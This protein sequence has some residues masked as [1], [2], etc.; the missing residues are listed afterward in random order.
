MPLPSAAKPI[1]P[2]VEQRSSKVAVAGV[3]ARAINLPGIVGAFFP[4]LAVNAAA[5]DK[6]AKEK[7]EFFGDAFF[8]PVFY[9]VTGF[10][11]DPLVFVPSIIGNFS[12]ASAICV[13]LIAGNPRVSIG[14]A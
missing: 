8:I 13:A 5:R 11:I 10:L 7:L 12:L 4:G 14:K 2:L 3:V 9:I 1:L 6:P